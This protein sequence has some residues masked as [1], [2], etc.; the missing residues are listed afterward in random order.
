VGAHHRDNPAGAE[1]AEDDMTEP[2]VIIIKAI[3]TVLKSPVMCSGI[4][5]VARAKAWGEKNGYA[6]VY[7]YHRMERCYAEGEKRYGNERT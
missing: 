3:P 4:P 5:T 2:K 7:Y 1:T 6:T